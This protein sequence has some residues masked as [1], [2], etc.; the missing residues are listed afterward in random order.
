MASRPTSLLSCTPA[1]AL[2]AAVLLALPA[3]AAPAP[4]KAP[5]AK[6]APAAAK[7]APKGSPLAP[8]TGEVTSA[9]APFSEGECQFCHSG[10][11]PKN[12]GPV[13]KAINPLCYECHEDYATQMKTRPVKHRPVV[14]SCVACHN[15]H[16]SDNRALLIKDTRS[17]CLGCHD[18]IKE[19]VDGKVKHQP[20]STGKQCINCH[21]P[22]S[23]NV[24]A[25]LIALPFDLC[26]KCHGAA[27]VKDE[28]GKQLT[29]FTKLLAENPVHHAPI[30]K[31]DCSAC[32]QVH[33]GENFRLLQNP[34]PAEFYA[35]YDPK[36]YAL[37]FECH[38]PEIAKTEHTDKLTR[39]RDG[40]R[41]LHYLH[42][43]REKGRTCRACHEVHASK[44][45]HQIRDGVP[46]GSSGWVLKV[47]FTPTANGGSCAK[48]CHATK[49][50]DNTKTK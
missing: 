42:I 48:T 26:Q 44:Q 43:N 4:A 12:P 34:Y 5:P 19:S 32:H 49:A 45:P 16:N 38:N 31:K 22:H 41:N 9:H 39:F 33:G 10:K 50:Y 25:L 21:N 47:N 29:N 14:D 46:Y 23:S 13:T 15:P 3:R 35:P 40:T 17:L 2:A 11:D 30:A 7:G 8:H 36:N 6:P 1:A 18:P 27:A 37:C 24:Q 28:A 20:V